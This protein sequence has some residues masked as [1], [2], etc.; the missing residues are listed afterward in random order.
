MPTYKDTTFCCSRNCKNACG[1]K[2]SHEESKKAKESGLPV[3]FSNFCD[4]GATVN[5]V[6][7]SLTG[8]PNLNGT[9][10]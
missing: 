5:D 8:F 7:S 2:L 4:E 10:H 3:S 6:L 9:V 1:K